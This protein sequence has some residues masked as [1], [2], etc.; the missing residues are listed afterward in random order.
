[1]RI[2]SG[3]HSARR[4]PGHRRAA[5]VGLAIALL[6]QAML[7]AAA[8][9][10]QDVPLDL[11]RATVADL[12]AAMGTGAL[13]SERLVQGYLARI[14]AIGEELGTGEALRAIGDRADLES[15]DSRWL[16]ERFQETRNL[17]DVVRLQAQR[18]REDPP[19]AKAESAPLR[20]AK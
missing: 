15:N 8:R 9:R 17:S 3:N 18:W 6:G 16:R 7:T 19:R 13:T 4:L 1:M 20:A 5:L 12:Q 2:H 11:E 10:V 14:Q